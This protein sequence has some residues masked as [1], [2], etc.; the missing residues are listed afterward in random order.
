MVVRFNMGPAEGTRL[1]PVDVVCALRLRADPD[2]SV[3][4]SEP[5]GPQDILFASVQAY[6][7]VYPTPGAM[8]HPQ[9]P[10]ALAG[11][12]YLTDEFH[13]ITA[14]EVTGPALLVP[15]GPNLHR[16]HDGRTARWSDSAVT[17]RVVRP[18]FFWLERDL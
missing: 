4:D 6:D 13:I 16:D 15:A 2:E 11:Y 17:A 5:A 12:V 3:G 8:S 1:Y 10:G 7:Y 14:Q 18:A 9:V